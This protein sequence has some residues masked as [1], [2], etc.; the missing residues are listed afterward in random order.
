M[1]EET[2]YSTY[3]V[4][5]ATFVCGEKKEVVQGIDL[6]YSRFCLKKEH[7]ELLGIEVTRTSENT[8][9]FTRLYK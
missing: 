3:Q 2:K 6:E 5:E 4:L 7:L 8:V 9:T 1:S